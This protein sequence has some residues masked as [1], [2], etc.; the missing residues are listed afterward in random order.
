MVDRKKIYILNLPSGGCNMPPFFSVY[1]TGFNSE[2]STNRQKSFLLSP[3]SRRSRILGPTTP[4]TVAMH[5]DVI[6]RGSTASNFIPGLNSF[7]GD[8]SCFK[9]KIFFDD[10]SKVIIFKSNKLTINKNN[11]YLKE[12]YLIGN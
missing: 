2:E 5:I 3:P 12:L 7:S 11:K 1:P 4:T 8:S 6:F 9:L 10:K